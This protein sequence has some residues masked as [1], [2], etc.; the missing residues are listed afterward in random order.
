MPCRA[1]A[2]ERYQPCRNPGRKRRTSRCKSTA[3][4]STMVCGPD[5][6]AKADSLV[7]K[8]SVLKRKGAGVDRGSTLS[9][10]VDVEPFQSKPFDVTKLRDSIH[11]DIFATAFQSTDPTTFD[12]KKLRDSVKA[13][14]RGFY[15]NVHK[16]SRLRKPDYHARYR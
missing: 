13:D 10:T 14:D 4:R 3:I 2:K 16:A 15:P 11:R 5:Q 6:A 7:A 8:M 12:V 9:G 1:D